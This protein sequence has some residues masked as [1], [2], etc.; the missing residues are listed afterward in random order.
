VL[1]TGIGLALARADNAHA[2]ATFAGRRPGAPPSWR[3]R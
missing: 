2:V 1:V 3:R